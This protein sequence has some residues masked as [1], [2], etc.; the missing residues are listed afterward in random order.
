MKNLCMFKETSPIRDSH[1]IDAILHRSTDLF[2]YAA[3]ATF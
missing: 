1:S 3:L 2:L